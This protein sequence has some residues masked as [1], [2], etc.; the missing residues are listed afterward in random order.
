[1]CG[2]FSLLNYDHSSVET[3]NMIEKYFMIGSKRG[4][5]YSHLKYINETLILGFH[6]LAINGLNNESNQPIKTS[7]IISITNGE[8]YNH[9]ELSQTFDFD[10]H[11]QSD[12]EV[13][14]HLYKLTSYNCFSM[15]DGVFSTVIYD[16]YKKSIIIARDPYGV[17]PLFICHYENGGIGFCSDVKPLM[18]DKNI[19]SIEQFE[20]GTYQIYNFDVWSQK[21]V[22]YRQTKYFICNDSLHCLSNLP[23]HPIEFYMKHFVDHLEKAIKKR[24]ESCERNICC[25]L[26]GGLDSSIISAYVSRF[27]KEKFEGKKLE[28]YS[29]GLKGATDFKYASMVSKHID[30][31]HCEVIKTNEDFISSI[32]IV[33][34]DI[35]SYDTTTIRASVGNWN[36]GSYIRETSDAKVVFNG[37]GADELMGGYMYFHK[38]PSNDSFH[39]ECVRLLNNISHYDVLRSDK[40]ISSHGLEPRTPFLDKELTQYYLNIPICYRN[41]VL[42]NQC[43]KYFIRKAIELFEPDLLPKE[44]LWRTKEAFSDGVSSIE[45]SWYEII[46]DNLSDNTEYD[47]TMATQDKNTCFMNPETKEQ[48]YYQSIFLKNY[49]KS[50][51]NLNKYYWMPKF[52]NANDSSA[53]T[54]DIYKVKQNKIVH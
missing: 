6:R 41:H 8:I 16:E 44:V 13:I 1:M 12:C 45:K 24:V 3:Y 47:E 48:K 27:Y 36:I 28:T 38:A 37:D 33:I 46:Q 52:I 30:S 2:I 35:E 22:L 34:E 40:S 53:R 51:V 20:P 4:P 49:D 25:L 42:N 23:L 17:R 10:L 11:T 21:Y 50:C 43:E 5:E 7:K 39:K 9:N 32:P 31:Q 15:L 54:L 18:F 19:L 29:I 14:N 26:S